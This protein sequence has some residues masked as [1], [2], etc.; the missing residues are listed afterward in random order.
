M[1]GLSHYDGQGGNYRSTD[2]GAYRL[3]GDQGYRA[4]D[5][6]GGGP[7]L[8]GAD[9]QAQGG[10]YLAGDPAGG[11][12]RTAGDNEGAYGRSCD[13]YGTYRSPSRS[14]GYGGS[15]GPSYRY[16]DEGDRS[17]WMD[18]YASFTHSFLR[19]SFG[20]QINYFNSMYN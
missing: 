13:S 2:S 4:G 3:G 10:A 11:A 12:Y 17:G 19:G 16:P 15:M 14:Y 18:F 6:A 7:Y 1:S 9:P 8:P 20:P 5:P